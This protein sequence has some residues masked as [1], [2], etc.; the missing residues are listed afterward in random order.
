VQHLSIV[1]K[2]LLSPAR[3]WL[4]GEA[5]MVSLPVPSGEVAGEQMVVFALFSAFFEAE[6]VTGFDLP[7]THPAPE[8]ASSDMHAQVCC[9][10]A[11]LHEEYKAN[12]CSLTV[13]IQSQK[14]STRS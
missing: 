11:R 2:E 14:M 5:G 4:E 1:T 3:G 9:I 8:S 10:S 12:L 7:N 13:K 6:G